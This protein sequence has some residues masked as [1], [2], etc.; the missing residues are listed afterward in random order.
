MFF[1]YCKDTETICRFGGQL[2]IMKE[3]NT[4]EWGDMELVTYLTYCS[5]KRESHT[6]HVKRNTTNSFRTCIA[7]REARIFTAQAMQNCPTSWPMM[8]RKKRRIVSTNSAHSFASRRT[9]RT[10]KDSQASFLLDRPARVKRTSKNKLQ[11]IAFYF[12]F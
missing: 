3:I 2:A 6:L 12:K 5:A 1:L 11:N 4:V 8:G 7:E 9:S 10:S